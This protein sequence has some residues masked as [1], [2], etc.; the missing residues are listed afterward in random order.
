MYKVLRNLAISLVA[1]LLLFT[2]MSFDGLKIF[3]ED[4]KTEVTY[5]DYSENA[6]VK[7]NAGAGGTE[8][9]K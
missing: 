8:A 6:N 3:A 2:S 4:N 1:T 9:S 5:E 7:L